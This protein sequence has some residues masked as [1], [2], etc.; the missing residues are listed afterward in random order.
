MRYGG[1]GNGMETQ[2]GF[3]GVFF[4][5]DVAADHLAMHDVGDELVLR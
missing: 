5:S 1:Y 3:L 4:A 2:R